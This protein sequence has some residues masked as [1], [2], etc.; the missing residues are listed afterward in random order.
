MSVRRLYQILKESRAIYFVL[1]LAT[2][3]VG[4]GIGTLLDRSVVAGRDEAAQLSVSSQAGTPLSLSTGFSEVAKKVEQAVVNINTEQRVRIADR[5]QGPPGFEDFFER[6]FGQEVPHDFV[7][8]SLGSGVIV[9]SNGYILTNNHVVEKATQINVKLKDGTVYRNVKVAGSDELSD[10]AILKIQ[11]KG[12]L[13][14][15]RLGDS[16]K[17]KV[18]DWVVAIGSPFGLEHTVTAGIISATSRPFPTTETFQA[19]VLQTDAAINPGNS[20]GPLVN[21]SGEVIG[22]NTA[23]FTQTQQF[24]GVGFAIPSRTVE[25]VYNQIVTAGGVSRGWLGISMQ[26]LT[27]EL[28][29]WRKAEGR[30]GV[31]VSDAQ[32][33]SPAEK[34]GL[35]SRDIIL[36]FDGQDVENTT[37]LQTKVTNTKPG[38]T[39]KLTIFR[40]G[41]EKTI[42]VVLA[43]RKLEQQ[44][45]R[46]GRFRLDEEEE[47]PPEKKEIGITVE[48]I[49]PAMARQMGLKSSEGALV[50][51]VTQ[52]SVADDAGLERNDV[53]VQINDKPVKDPE[54]LVS[55]I[56]R[57]PS[58]EVVVLEVLTLN[59]GTR[60]FS[61]RYIGFTKP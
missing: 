37:D 18:G 55:A 8:R 36:K 21:L 5:R 54:D 28:A 47:Q 14:A 41:S 34:A 51:Q 39:V 32:E 58:G 3:G 30:K 50:V 44:M 40:D 49:T 10:L 22:I 11:P 48:P 38:E 13:P 56:R 42:S 17:L 57:L 19:N 33:G 4:I 24:A 6:F 60:D 43:E 59:P 1:I 61:K 12:S 27:P 20:G 23:I 52:G 46:G 25:M 31:L 9:D 7:Q 16:D 15:A 26:P 29:Q 53:V 2:M 35:R 45:R